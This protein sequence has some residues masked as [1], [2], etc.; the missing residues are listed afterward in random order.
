[1]PA[2]RNGKQKRGDGNLKYY[3]AMSNIAPLNPLFK[4]RLFEFFDFD[5]KKTFECSPDDIKRAN[6]RYEGE[7]RPP[8]NFF[9]L[10]DKINPDK[11]YEDFLSLENLND[12]KAYG[13]GALTFEDENYPKLLKNI[14]DFPLMLYFKGSFEGIN[15]ERAIAFVGSRKASNSAKEALNGIISGFKGTDVV[16][17]SGLAEGID[18]KSH[19]S[20]LEYDLK[21]VAVTGS[22]FKFQYPY[23]NRYL[24]E[25]IQNNGLILTEYPYEMPPLPVQFPLRN[26][27]V[28]GLC[29]GTVVAEARMKSGAMISAKLTLENNRELMCIPGLISNPNTEG[30]YYLLKN[31]ASLVTSTQ[32]V[33]DALNFDIEACKKEELPL[34]EIEKMIY[35]TIASG[36]KNID[37]IA[38][39]TDIDFNDLTANLTS[40]ELKGLIKQAAGNYFIKGSG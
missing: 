39:S 2:N 23:T 9:E 15:F 26:R 28:T 35:E 8:K 21:T 24:Y 19:S 25:K 3:L 31:G 11:T 17:V 32:D 18:A 5:I 30:I 7:L 27:I 22:G 12:K 40:M 1:M 10:R 6:D 4:A 29:R 36:A 14:P 20:A 37:D 38:L 16:I 13:I 34:N 33:L